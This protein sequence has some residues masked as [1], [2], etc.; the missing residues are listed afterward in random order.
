MTSDVNAIF[1]Y[2][3]A[4][5]VLVTAIYAVTASKLLN[6]ALSL[7]LSFF[8]IGGLFFL[9]G[10]PF[11]GMLQIL[12]NAGAIPIVTVFILFMTQSRQVRLKSPLSA[13]T[14]FIAF[15]PLGVAL[16][17]YLFRSWN[18]GAGSTTV[19]A[20]S[21][22]KIGEHLLSAPETTGINGTLLA[23]EVA[24]VILLVAMVGA[25]VLTKRDGETIKGEVGVLSEVDK[26]VRAG[27]LER[28]AV[29][30][31][32]EAQLEREKELVKG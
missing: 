1:F 27:E 22:A 31:E 30:I 21:P 19:T 13:V 16:G 14:A 3:I 29:T 26:P 7:A 15:V 25:I 24:S 18:A 32:R 11:L 28:P 9:L 5:A 23:F 17:A 8:A 2:L 20:V 6:A 12:I 4:L 10:T